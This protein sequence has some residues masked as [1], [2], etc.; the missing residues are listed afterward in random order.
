MFAKAKNKPKTK[1]TPL[2]CFYSKRKKKIMNFFLVIH[3]GEG[4]EERRTPTHIEPQTNLKIE[5]TKTTKKKTSSRGRKCKNN[6]APKTPM[7]DNTKDIT[8]SIDGQH[9][10]KKEKTKSTH[11]RNDNQH[12]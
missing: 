7:M 12:H 3:I 10:Q 4:H 9:Y 6:K 2:R 1:R 5:T 8:S 11:P